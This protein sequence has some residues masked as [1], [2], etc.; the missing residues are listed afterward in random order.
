MIA[1]SV[2]FNIEKDSFIYLFFCFHLNYVMFWNP[3]TP[4]FSST[5]LASLD[6]FLTNILP[7]LLY[8]N[9]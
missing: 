1:L 3:Y 4:P 8:T 9:L 6:N 5:V 2:W 7:F